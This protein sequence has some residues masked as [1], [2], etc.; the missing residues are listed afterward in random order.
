MRTKPTNEEV[1]KVDVRLV[2]RVAPDMEVTREDL[3]VRLREAFALQPTSEEPSYVVTGIE[4]GAF[5]LETRPVLFT[6]RVLGSGIEREVRDVGEWLDEDSL[7]TVSLLN[8]VVQPMLQEGEAEF[9]GDVYKVEDAPAFRR[10]L[11]L[12]LDHM[13]KRGLAPSTKQAVERTGG[14]ALKAMGEMG[15]SSPWDARES[16]A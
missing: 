16:R 11:V 15:E 7:T 14:L 9:A 5:K 3:E 12:C 1:L 13:E 6:C 2:L 10:A 8:S 4:V